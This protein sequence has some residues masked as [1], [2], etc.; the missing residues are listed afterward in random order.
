[1]IK[2]SKELFCLDYIDKLS[3]KTGFTKRKGKLSAD[4]FMAF[5]IFSSE[6][7]CTK[8]LSTLCARFELQFETLISPQSLNERFND[9]SVEFMQE[10]FNSMLIKQN[11]LLSSKS[12]ILPKI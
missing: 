4:S 6:D 9:N 11:K 10:V 8:S 2:V 5:N 12:S 3:K 1:M 7:M